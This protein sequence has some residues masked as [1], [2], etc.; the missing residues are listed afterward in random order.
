MAVYFL[1]AAG[2]HQ[3][4]GPALLRG[5]VCGFLLGGV[6][7]VGPSAEVPVPECDVGELLQPGV[8]RLEQGAEPCVAQTQ[9]PGRGHPDKIWEINDHTEWQQENQGKLGSTA[10]SFEYIAFGELC[11]LTS[12]ASRQSVRKCGIHGKMLNDN[13]DFTTNYAGKNPN[14]FH[15]QGESLFH[16]KHEQTG[17]TYCENNESGKATNKKSPL[18]CQQVCQRENA[19]R[20]R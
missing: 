19:F 3:A 6:A 5:R 11:L 2:N 9:S 17:I 18:I 14:G 15:I 1:G 16:S 13:I 12:Y 7:A 10:K 20:S 8:P 4:L